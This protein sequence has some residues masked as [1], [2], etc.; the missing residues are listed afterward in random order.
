[1]SVTKKSIRAESGSIRKATSI[2]KSGAPN[3][4]AFVPIGIQLQRVATTGW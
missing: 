4:P 1:M 3:Q 2:E